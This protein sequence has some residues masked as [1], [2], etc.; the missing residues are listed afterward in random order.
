[1]IIKKLIILAIRTHKKIIKFKK[2][3]KG[4]VQLD[5]S[6]PPHA[7]SSASFDP[8]I[9]ASEHLSGIQLFLGQLYPLQQ[10]LTAADL[11]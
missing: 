3:Q 6:G 4:G 5:N 11:Q 10:E 1:M 7:S 9:P 2:Y 8:S